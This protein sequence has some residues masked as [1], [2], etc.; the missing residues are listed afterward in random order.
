MSIFKQK[1]DI[2]NQ[3]QAK[4]IT[5]LIF[6]LRTNVLVLHLYWIQWLKNSYTEN[7]DIRFVNILKYCRT[8]LQPGEQQENQ[9]L[10]YHKP[11]FGT[12]WRCRKGGSSAVRVEILLIVTIHIVTQSFCIGFQ[13]SFFRIFFCNNMLSE[14]LYSQRMQ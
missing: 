14:I 1:S 7:K 3:I 13:I 4:S 8:F 2:L 11:L 9:D 5:S 10:S 6:D 12:I